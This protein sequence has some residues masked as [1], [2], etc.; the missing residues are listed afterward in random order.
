MGMKQATEKAGGLHA[1]RGVLRA[2][3]FLG[4]GGRDAN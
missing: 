4:K 2:P 3:A 1:A